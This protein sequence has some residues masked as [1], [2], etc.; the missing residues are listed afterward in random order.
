[1]CVYMCGFVC[2]LQH[3]EQRILHNCFADCNGLHGSCSVD[4]S[5][6]HAKGLQKQFRGQLKLSTLL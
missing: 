5:L 3:A 1:M 4:S 2:G 6:S